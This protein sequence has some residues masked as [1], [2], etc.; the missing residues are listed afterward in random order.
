M[1]SSVRSIR[2]VRAAAAF[3]SSTLVAALFSACADETPTS[4][5]ARPVRPLALLSSGVQVSISQV[6]GGGGNAGATIKNDFIELYNR[7]TTAVDLTGWSVQYASA[8][9]TSWQV[10]ALSGSIA[11]GG[12]YLVK[13]AA[14][15]GGTVDL[16]TADATGTIAM[17]ATAGKVALVNVSTALTGTCPFG[18]Q[19]IDVVGYGTTATCFE[20]P[21][22]APTLTNT[23]AAI[24]TD[25]GATDTDN[26]AADFVTGVPNPRNSVLGLPAIRT[27]VPA[28]NATSVAIA[29]NIVITFNKPVTITGDWYTIT[30][31]TSGA[32]TATITGGGDTYTLDP[33][34]DFTSAEQCTVTVKGSQVADAADASIT[35][36]ADQTWTFT[37]ADLAS[38]NDPF[39]PIYSI[40]GSGLATP[41]PTNVPLTTQ[42]VVVGDYEGP[43]PALR[44]FYLQDATGDDN[45]ATS[46]GLF[47][48]NVN[49]DNVKV[50][51]VVRVTGKPEEFQDQTQL[52]SVTGVLVC[53]S[54]TSVNPVEVMLPVPSPTFLE[55]FEGM[56]VR[57][58]QTLYVTEHFQL[59]RFGQVVMSSGSRLYQP[60][61]L[62]A[63]GA[64]AQAMQ[65]QNDLNRIIVDDAVNDQNPDP[66]L[67]GRGGNPLTAGNTL[68]GGDAATGMTGVLTY[69]WA[70][71]SASGNA[72]RL[73][74]IG[75][76]G[77]A[78]PSF[79]A[80]NA[81]PANPAPVGGSLR[82][83]A[84]NL[85]NFFN[86]FS[87]CTNGVG[88]AA[89][90]CRG[91]SNA[92][93]FERQWPKTVAAIVALDADVLGVVEIENDGYGPSS[94]LA[95]LVAK[96]N[97]VAGAG[98]YAF[99][100]VDAGVGQVN[101]LG[102]DAI[103]VGLLYKPAAVTPVGTTAALNT[104]AFV[105]GGDGFPRNR[106]A[107]AQA[108]ERPDHGRVVVSVNH[109]KS[110]G[111]ECD[112]PDAG[113]GQ[114][115]C[116]A[117]RTA[118]ANLLKAWLATDPTGMVDSD[119]I[120]VGDMN[121][122]ARE[123]PITALVSGGFT[124][125]MASRIGPNAYSYVFDGQWGYLDH[126]LASTSLT[127]QVT[128]VTEWHIN[129]DE[130]SVLDY[131]TDFKSAAQQVSLY[132]SDQF[133]ISDHDPLLVGLNLTPTEIYAFGGFLAPLAPGVNEA[134][135]GSSIPL[136]FS[137]GGNRGTSIFAPGYPLSRAIACPG[138]TV[139]NEIAA[140]ES[141]GHSGLSYDASTDAYTYAWK[142]EKAWANTCRELVIKLKDATVWTAT[143]RFRK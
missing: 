40:Q 56:L 55:R 4:V 13:E 128:G 12:Y 38:C 17:S 111:S 3:L 122:Y 134:K 48:F 14:G 60:T 7:G 130:P 36:P 106:P 6:Y 51:D 141:S 91:A 93:E 98:T 59:G 131:L 50:G 10:T 42:G 68:R 62:V 137:L 89:T 94:A 63:P 118:A 30:C 86:T 81:R 142:T 139:D 75:S 88:G 23:T 77:G 61:S 58:P 82:V 79:V 28:A 27:T 2:R 1:L 72:Y 120:I 107:L 99:I 18:S 74:P 67:F 69:T 20:G 45:P 9:G 113:D 5:A 34:A 11:P 95:D 92:A 41:L 64:A 70:G 123:D 104:V 87:G 84:M 16:P 127:S 110:K 47:V 125:L 109:L 116:A 32:H 100:D 49:N 136:N 44:G 57:F 54:G 73:R 129:S 80:L 132:S 133:R 105:N 83:G 78:V 52:G 71:N 135:A 140:T 19:I 119:V 29:S 138:G 37:I 53:G 97:V 121:S 24:R 33:D 114:G 65:A 22:A 112:A 124:D 35:M 101:A 21:G 8:A 85:L 46:D 108:F 31:A 39:T 143:L 76:L 126:A 25:G 96:V 117:V 26:N 102:T 90:D 15:A 43:T 115:N 103:K 66:I